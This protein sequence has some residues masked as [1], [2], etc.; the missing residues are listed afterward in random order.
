MGRRGCL[1]AIEFD[2]NLQLQRMVC[3]VDI[4]RAF[5]GH[6][7]ASLQPLQ[8]PGHFMWMEECLRIFARFQNVRLHFGV[9]ALVAALAV[10]RSTSSSPSAAP[11]PG[12]KVTSPLLS[13][14][15][16]CVVMGVPAQL[17]VNLSGCRIELDRN[18][19]CLA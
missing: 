4:E 17:P 19:R 2:L 14:K 9:A 7:L 1:V 15:V 10:A 11:V 3:A 18:L 5:G 8:A 6:G 13:R 12:S 16:P